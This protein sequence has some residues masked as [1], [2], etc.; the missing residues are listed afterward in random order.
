MTG[1]C[2]SP[3]QLEIRQ[4]L[5]I[6]D[7]EADAQVEQHF[8]RCPYCRG[9]A[10]DLRRLQARL[11]ARGYRQDCPSSLDLGE[12]QLGLLVPAQAAVITRHLQECPHCTREIAQLRD[13]LVEFEPVASRNQLGKM[14]VLIAR[15]VG[16]IGE[17]LQAGG[18][19]PSLAYTPLRG[20]SSG[21]V[22]LQADGI[23]ITLEIR[24]AGE[25]RVNLLGQV[26][27]E[28]QDRWTG[29]SVE[30]RQAGELRCTASVDDLGAFRC[31]DLPPG[32]G[33]LSIHP[34]NGPDVQV[35]VEIVAEE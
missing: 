2:S 28:D 9:R 18:I 17:S 23:L 11:T 15:L 7:G 19:T 14:S 33:E 34:Q 25:G 31:P 21:P 20:S 5:A 24:P 30:L 35:N 10:E 13:Y 29:A 3:P 27:S 6:L 26:A 32:P 4:L 16:G 22:L 1:H 12:Y 8:A